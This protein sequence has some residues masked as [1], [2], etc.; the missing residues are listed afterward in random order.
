MLAPSHQKTLHWTSE[1]DD[2]EIL[3]LTRKHTYYALTIKLLCEKIY[4][5]DPYTRKHDFWL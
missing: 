1:A 4:K 2:I 3:S 5:E